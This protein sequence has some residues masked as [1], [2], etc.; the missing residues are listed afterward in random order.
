MVQFRDRM[1][2][3]R[4]SAKLT[5]AELAE[6]CHMATITIRQYESG[7]RQPGL[8]QRTAIVKALD[9]PVSTVFEDGMIEMP[10]QILKRANEN[11]FEFEMEK[12]R[13]DSAYQLLN[14]EGKRIAAELIE[15]LSGN[16]R[17][18]SND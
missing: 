3:A 10:D 12:Q 18:K 8:S 17:Y 14:N 2:E 4:K 15:A 6:K 7:K 11:Y 13:I 16:S 5:Q 1:R 9:L